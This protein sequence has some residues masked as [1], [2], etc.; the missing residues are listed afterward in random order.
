MREGQQK[1]IKNIKKTI[2]DLLDES[3]FPLLWRK[4]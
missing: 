1:F 3:F 4:K 2:V